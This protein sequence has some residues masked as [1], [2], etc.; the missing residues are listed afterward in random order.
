ME[1]PGIGTFSL[2]A[3]TVIPQESDRMGHV[4]ASGINFLNANIPVADD[5]LIT[6][7]KEHTG[8]MKSRAAADLDFSLTTG[9]QLLNIGKPFYLEGIGTLVK[10]KDGRLDFT[11]GEFLVPKLD[12]LHHPEKKSGAPATGYD[13]PPR[14]ERPNNNARQTLLLVMIVAGIAIVG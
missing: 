8:K 4:S 7:I 14:E 9:R 3:A 11:P 13:E 10:L 2:D 6:Y 5:A 1:L 12:D